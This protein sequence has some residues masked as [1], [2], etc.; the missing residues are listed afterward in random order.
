MKPY[1]IKQGIFKSKGKKYYPG[2]IIFLDDKIV[3][4]HSGSIREAT[5]DEIAMF[6]SNHIPNEAA[7]I[8]NDYGAVSDGEVTTEDDIEADY[9]SGQKSIVEK[10]SQKQPITSFKSEP[11]GKGQTTRKK[12][13][14]KAK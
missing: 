11:N 3:D 2:D 7:S 8:D 13:L 1:Y 9:F 5:D 6:D 14:T 4:S 10:K 12:R